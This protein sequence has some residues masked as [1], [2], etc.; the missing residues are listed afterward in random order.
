MHFQRPGS[1][2]SG[3]TATGSFDASAIV[4]FHAPGGTGFDAPRGTGRATE[5]QPSASGPV[6]REYRGRQ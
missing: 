5:P 2:A 1:N 6:G 4:G 3:T